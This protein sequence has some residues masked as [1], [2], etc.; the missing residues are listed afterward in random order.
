MNKLISKKGEHYENHLDENI[1]KWFAVYTPYKREKIAAKELA[2]GGLEVYLPVHTLTRQYVRKVKT[3]ELP[4][5]NHYVFVK[6]TKKEY[7][8]V[9]QCPY[10]LQFVK[11]SKNLVSIPEEEIDL[12]KRILGETEAVHLDSILFQKGDEV[13]VIGGNLTGLKGVLIQKENSQYLRVQ[14]TNIGISLNVSIAAHLLRKVKS[15]ILA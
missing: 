2:K 3:V 15:G 6:I 5:I 11:F 10:V 9:L 14:L 12:I 13:E 1:P 7:I 8:R 4:L